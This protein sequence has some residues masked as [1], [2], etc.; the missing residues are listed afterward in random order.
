MTLAEYK[1]GT[2]C[3]LVH[4]FNT[5]PLPFHLLVLYVAAQLFLFHSSPIFKSCLLLILLTSTQHL[6][7]NFSCRTFA[8]FS[9][10]DSYISPLIMFYS[11]GRVPGGKIYPS[12]S[13]KDVF[14]AFL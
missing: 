7:P 8:V 14:H 13:L 3:S 4:G 2:F 6:L 9:R 11:V 5:C 10:Y 12:I 1:S